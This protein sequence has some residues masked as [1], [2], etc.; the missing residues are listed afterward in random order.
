MNQKS[1][2]ETPHIVRKSVKLNS[3]YDPCPVVQKPPSEE[4]VGEVNVANVD[5]KVQ[6]LAKEILQK[7][8]MASILSTLTATQDCTKRQRLQE[9]KDG[10][11]LLPE[12]KL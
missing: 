5:H 3:L 2:L 12:A 9:E 11:K 8:M 7:N 1:L 4:D 10:K 6:E